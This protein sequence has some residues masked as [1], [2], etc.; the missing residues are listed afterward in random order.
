MIL[1]QKEMELR[2]EWRAP[3]TIGSFR[4][5]ELGDCPRYI[6]Y[7]LQGY[8]GEPPSPELGML[9]ADGHLHHDAV[10]AELAKVGRVTNR[11]FSAWK[12]FEVEVGTR[13]AKFNLTGTLD[14]VFNGDFIF[15][16][17]SINPFSFKKLSLPY[18]YEKYRGYVYQLQT[19]MELLDKQ[20]SFNLFKDKAFS[21]MKIFWYQRDP[22]VFNMVLKKMAKIHLATVDGKW[23]KQPFSKSSTECE[24]CTMRIHCWKKPMKRRSW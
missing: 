20:W 12:S 18:I 24:R 15:D 13:V 10:R 21:G 5:S 2:D 16:I 4:G 1:E 8:K 14:G 17:K 9:F 23:I 11:E 19:Y 7:V 3:R 6:Q 22:R